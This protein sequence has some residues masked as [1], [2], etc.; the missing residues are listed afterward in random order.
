MI[1]SVALVPVSGLMVE[2]TAKPGTFVSITTGK[3]PACSAL[4]AARSVAVALKAYKP[5]ARAL[6]I[7]KDQVP[8]ARAV[9]VPTTLV[10]R[11]MET[12]EPGSEVPARVGV[13]LPVSQ[14]SSMSNEP[15]SEFTPGA[16]RVVSMVTRK[17]SEIGET[18][19]AISVERA[20]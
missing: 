8:S 16:P 19:A 1:R 9:V 6:G 20:V 2:K 7:V 5:S 13:L 14:P 10:P 15:V 3:L 17:A 4:L 11:K 18:T 12:V